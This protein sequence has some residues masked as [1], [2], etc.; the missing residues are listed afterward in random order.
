VAFMHSVA[1]LIALQHFS[2][3]LLDTL[4]RGISFL[5]GETFYLVLLVFLYF[6]VHRKLAF[7]LALVVLGSLYL[8]FLFK[9]FFGIPRPEGEGLRVLEKP[10]DFSFPSGHAQSV[11]SFWFFLAFSFP[12]PFFFFLAAVLSA[13]VS[14]S[15]LYLGVHYLQ[16]VLFGVVLG[17]TVAFL[18]FR[19]FRFFSARKFPVL[20]TVPFLA[21][22][23]FLLFFFAP[24]SLGVKV[25]G[26]LSG[27]LWGYW[28]AS[29]FR[30]PERVFSGWECTSGAGLLVLL[31]LGG[32]VV[33]FAGQWWLFTRYAMLNAFA[34]FVFPFLAEV[35][36]RK[37][38]C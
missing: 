24:S 23:S 19:L 7:R 21:L 1:L 13:L 17:V 29:F 3:P 6:R 33:P 34:V 35:L 15:R 5:G 12:R 10:E 16:D 18:F 20:V 32:K 2:S 11:A 4:F 9:N 14:F 27:I 25:A 28:L 37:K 22:L 30:L 31:Y 8:N 26:A 36:R 38:R